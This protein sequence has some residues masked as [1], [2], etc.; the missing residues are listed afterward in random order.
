MLLKM[1][2]R[3]GLVDFLCEVG[4]NRWL[5]K[6]MAKM[7]EYMNGNASGQNICTVQESPAA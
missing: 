3:N 4:R 1:R 5:P 7:N 2:N 6:L